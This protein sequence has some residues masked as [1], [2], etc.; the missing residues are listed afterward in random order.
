LILFFYI[1]FNKGS[2]QTH[3]ASQITRYADIYASTV[4]NLVYYPFFYFF[5]AVPQLVYHLINKH[6][7]FKW[8]FFSLQ[9]PHES[10]VDPEEPMH[11]KSWG[12]ETSQSEAVDRRRTTF[13]QANIPRFHHSISMQ[14][15]PDL[16]LHVTHDHDDDG[17]PDDDNSSNVNQS[18]E[19]DLPSKV[20]YTP[21]KR[22]HK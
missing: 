21:P 16:P 19:L 17:D 15:H 6:H 10:T 11:F 20:T 1:L 14:T 8:I 2:R 3:F 5:R 22:K 7:Y 18:F 9:M 13:D 12:D 4:V